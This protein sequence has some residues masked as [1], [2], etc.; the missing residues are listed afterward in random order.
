LIAV[1][2]AGALVA[3]DK[4]D[5]AVAAMLR[6]LQRDSVPVRTSAGVVAQVWRDG[7]RQ[8]NLARVLPGVDVAALDEGAAKN[9]G[10]LLKISR[11]SDVVDAHVAYLAQPDGTVL[12]SDEAEIR[13]LLRTRKVNA[14]IV[15]V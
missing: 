13:S 6:I 4:G 10:E 7:R 14:V 1:L 9:I 2:D 8:S 11:T 12:T 5:R 3:I 15:R